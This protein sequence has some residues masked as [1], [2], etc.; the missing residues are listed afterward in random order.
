MEQFPFEYAVP[1]TQSFLDTNLLFPHPRLNLSD[2]SGCRSTFGRQKSKFS[3]PNPLLGV[4][5]RIF[6]RPKSLLG[7]KNRI[8]RVPNQSWESK[9]DFPF[10]KPILGVKNRFSASQIEFWASQINFPRPKSNFGR[11]KSIFRV[12]NQILGADK[13]I[14]GVK[15]S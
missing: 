9:I 3:R 6:S 4:K 5:N 12:P 2:L 10:P 1:S 14:W 11:L 7:V 8:F 13:S 15:K